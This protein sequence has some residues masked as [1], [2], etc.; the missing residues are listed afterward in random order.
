[1]KH[2]SNGDGTHFVAFDLRSFP[3]K[4]E[5]LIASSHPLSVMDRR[6]A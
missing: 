5:I 4:P 6:F 3:S 2:K 1:M